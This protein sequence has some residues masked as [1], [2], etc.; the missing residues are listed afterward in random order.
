MA[1][2]DIQRAV[3]Y[4]TTWV[5]DTG[6]QDWFKLCKLLG[7]LKTKRDETL[8][9]KFGNRNEIVWYVDATFAVPNDIKSHTGAIMT[10]GEEPWRCWLPSRHYKE[11][12]DQGR[13]SNDNKKYND[14][15]SDDSR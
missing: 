1:R 14:S 10:L 5:E 9:L 13:L 8:S 11:V 6:E 3:A 2:S 15:N 4:L 12:A 7:L